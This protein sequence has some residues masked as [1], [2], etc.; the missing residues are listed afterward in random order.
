MVDKATIRGDMRRRRRSLSPA[1]VRDAGRAVERRFAALGLFDQASSL[2][3]YCDAE[4]EVRTAGLIAAAHRSGIRVALPSPQSATGFVGYSAGDSLTTGRWGIATPEGGEPLEPEVGAI[5]LLPLVACAAPG[6]RLG[7]GLGWYDRKA[8]GWPAGVL[9]VGLGYDF[10]LAEDLPRD[11]WDV[12]LHLMVSERREVVWS[13]PEPWK[14]PRKEDADRNGI[15]V[16]SNHQHRTG[17]RARLGNRQ[18]AN[19]AA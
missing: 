4:N 9:R 10:Q 8:A 17:G 19:S 2:F 13:V 16:D 12:P 6:V 5:V 1:E 18:A 3:A 7:R 11:R 15:R 14:L